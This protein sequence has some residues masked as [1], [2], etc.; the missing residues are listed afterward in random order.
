MNI[1]FCSLYCFRSASC[2]L[3]VDGLVQQSKSLRHDGSR[4]LRRGFRHDPNHG[5]FFVGEI[6]C[7][8]LAGSAS[9]FSEGVVR[10]MS[11]TENAEVNHEVDLKGV[12]CEREGY[13]KVV[14]RG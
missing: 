7:G 5:A 8:T 3:G 9:A 13:S 10:S 1:I 11:S 2:S 12:F 14:Q 4:S 6:F